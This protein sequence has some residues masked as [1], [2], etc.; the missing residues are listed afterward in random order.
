MKR[1]KKSL[2]SLITIISIIASFSIPASAATDEFL[3]GSK[4]TNASNLLYYI[5]TTPTTNPAVP[6]PYAF[7]TL[8]IKD[9]FSRWNDMMSIYGVNVKFTQTTNISSANIIVKYAVV[10]GTNAETI[11]TTSGTTITKATIQ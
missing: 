4:W 3:I 5:D 7:Y 6:A 10:P 9:A 2:I 11:L 8:D 1:M